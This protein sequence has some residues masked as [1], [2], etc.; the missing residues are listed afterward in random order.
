MSI[1]AAVLIPS[2]SGLSLERFVDENDIQ[3]RMS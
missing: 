3:R 1:G 2:S